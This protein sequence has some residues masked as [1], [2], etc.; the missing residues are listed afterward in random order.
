MRE[1]LTR[2]GAGDATEN[3]DRQS[4]RLQSGEMP[5]CMKPS[6]KRQELDLPAQCRSARR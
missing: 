1:L 6:C 3:R 4:Q 5:P 2:S